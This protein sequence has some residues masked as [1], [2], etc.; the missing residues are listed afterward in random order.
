MYMCV[1]ACIYEDQGV[2]SALRFCF[3]FVYL[4][5]TGFLYVA[6]ELSM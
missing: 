4:F 1:H 5:E 2:I 6:L 3:G